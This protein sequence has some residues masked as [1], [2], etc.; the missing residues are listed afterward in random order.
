LQREAEGVN[1]DEMKRKVAEA[2]LEYVVPD[3]IIGV[4][5]G[6]TANMFIDALAGMRDRIIGAVA[7]SE[8]TAK[9][10]I[11]HGVRVLDL[12]DVTGNLSVYVDG[13]DEFDAEK[14]LT[15]GGGG[16]LTREKIVAAAS[17][18]FICIVDE[19]KKVDVLGDFPL[20]VEVIPMARNLIARRLADLGGRPV[21]REGFITDNGNEIID[22]HDLRISDPRGLESQLNQLPGVVTNGLFALRGADVILM[23]T[24][25]GVERIE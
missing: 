11:G 16:A 7:S 18:M 20:P 15:K 12:N 24:A 5:T 22:V 25:T 8:V 13:A 2:A 10:L 6:S 4:G 17:E 9:R 23:G 3:T 21:L 1:Q 19:T 14:C